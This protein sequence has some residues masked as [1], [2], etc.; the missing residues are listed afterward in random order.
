MKKVL[1]FGSRSSGDTLAHELADALKVPGVEFIKCE[2][3]FDLFDCLGDELT[4][5]DTVKGIADVVVISD[6]E[7]IKP[8]KSVTAHDMDLGF[9]LRLLADEGKIRG[10]KLIGVP[11]E[12]EVELAKTRV[13]HLI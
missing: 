13:E 7:N 8:R 11:M 4:I 10:L 12:W 1:C 5:I 6:V 3:P 9:M 2:S